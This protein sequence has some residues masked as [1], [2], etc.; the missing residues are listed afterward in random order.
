M[1]AAFDSNHQFCKEVTLSV[2]AAA[3]SAI[4]TQNFTVVGINP[5]VAYD[6]Q[7]PVAFSADFY[8]FQAKALSKDTLQ[9]AF[10]NATGS[11]IAHA[12]TTFR[13]TSR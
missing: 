10:F 11:S 1:A 4:T 7:A 5:L 3:A 8:V 12:S 2:G 9:V 13:I 6:V